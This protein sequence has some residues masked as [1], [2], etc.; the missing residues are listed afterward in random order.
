MFERFFRDPWGSVE[1]ES[2]LAE[3]RAFPRADL[4]ESDEEVT[5]TMELPGIDPKDGEISLSG[6]VL[7]VRGEKKHEE[8]EKRKDYHYVERDFGSFHRSVQVPSSVDPEKV[9]AKFTN[10]VLTVTL[11]KRPDAKPKEIKIVEA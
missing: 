5:V 11:K 3:L 9:D 2:P 1:W 8:E 10:G 6:D 7:T 4:A